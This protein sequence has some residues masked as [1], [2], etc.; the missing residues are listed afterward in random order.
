[1]DGIGRVSSLAPVAGAV[2]L[3]VSSIAA[4]WTSGLFA[5]RG[6]RS[7]SRRRNNSWGGSTRH[8]PVA[9]SQREGDPKTPY[10]RVQNLARVR[11]VVK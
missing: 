10:A 1:M 7:T 9:T 3:A 5:T 11:V 2:A 4:L 6:S 8:P